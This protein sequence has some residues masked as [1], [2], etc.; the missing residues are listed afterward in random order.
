MPSN[1]QF[2]RRKCKS[3]KASNKTGVFV[4][5]NPILSEALSPSRHARSKLVGNVFG[6]TDNVPG[7]TALTWEECWETT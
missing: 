1:T 2:K 7:A 3:I 4:D 6:R 5:S